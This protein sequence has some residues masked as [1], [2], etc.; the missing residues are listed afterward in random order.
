M[1]MIIKEPLSI[2]GVFGYFHEETKAL[3]NICLGEIRSFNI[4]RNNKKIANKLLIWTDDSDGHFTIT[5]A[6][7]IERFTQE[8]NEFQNKKYGLI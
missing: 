1:K 7:T 2:F 6:K 8:L 3:I 4:E 5:N